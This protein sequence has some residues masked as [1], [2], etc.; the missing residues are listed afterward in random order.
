MQAD[1]DLA[2]M[3]AKHHTTP[4]F[5]WEG[6]RDDIMK[7][8][9]SRREAEREMWANEA[10]R[11]AAFYPERSDGRNTFILFSESIKNRDFEP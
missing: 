7:A 10:R 9:G 6:L 8:F 4:G 2:E 11:L 1:A 5:K 3:I